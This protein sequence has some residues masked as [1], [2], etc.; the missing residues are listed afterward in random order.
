MSL[1][2]AGR[3]R[4]RRREDVAVDI[5]L[6]LLIIVCV[7]GAGSALAR[8]INV[9]APLL[10]TLFGVI[11]SVLPF[12]PRVS[13]PPD[14]ILIGILPPL[15]FGAA[16]KTSL[17]DFTANRRPIALLSVGYV[18]AG[19]LVIGLV[20]HLLIP[21]LPLAAAFALGAVVAPP[22]A[23]AATA[24]ARKVGLPR[25]TVVILEG[26]SLVNDA[27]A[28]VCLRTSLA[29]LAGQVP[30]LGSIAGD[31]LLSAGGGVAIGLV[32][33]LV[34]V[35]IR[36][37]IQDPVL[38][39]TLSLAAPYLAYLP[40]EEAHAS[41][42]LAVVVA[43]LLIGHKSPLMPSG[44]SRMNERINWSTVEFLLENSVFLLIGLQ[45]AQI[46]SDAD[47]DPL[48]RGRV[49]LICGLVL[50]AVL[51]FRVVWVYPATFL[52]R[53]LVPS[54]RA[55]EPNPGWQTPLVVSW[56]GLRGVVTL[57]AAF[58]IPGETEHRPVLVLAALVVV[59][60][61]LLLQGLT[62]PRLVRALGLRGPDR[63]EDLLAAASVLRDATSAGLAEL[64]RLTDN[65]DMPEVL[66]MIRRRTEERDQA[67]WEK[68]GRPESDGRT[69]SR[70]YIELRLAMLQAE[71]SA[72]LDLRGS[73]T[74][75]QDVLREV[76]VRLDV[77]ESM[78]D[79]AGVDQVAD[80]RDEI[81]TTPDSQVRAAHCQHLADAADHPVADEPK[82]LD[83]I[84][85]GTTTVHLRMCLTCGNVGCCDSSVG[86]HADRHFHD[87]QHP[88]MR[89][90]EP[91]EAWRWCYVDE[92]L[93]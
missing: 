79:A 88:V 66:D 33:A 10:L 63:R 52:P 74:V 59:G 85:E 49:W 69:P 75:A 53:L 16:L 54:I 37:H 44:T 47:A 93:G 50:V 20:V 90:I 92:L 65:D 45:V 8:R 14:L 87:T 42:V 2:Q 80:D 13:L 81:L 46:V 31:F 28:L 77:E 58:A 3:C 24:I 39:T 29:V 38:N 5:T 55:R 23:V 40:A 48:G 64:D 61:T 82:C 56:A 15:L 68:L 51:I 4:S 34:L 83:C 73:G 11:G 43:G 57:A 1:P 21:S 41:G 9:S 70:R 86:R 26:E 60:G 84:R 7:V 62:L 27:T 12:I 17:I 32:V 89:S 19:T 6:G 71:R 35:W 36:R 18:L 25:R 30:S 67:A 78:L 91:G 76:L 22:D 72:V